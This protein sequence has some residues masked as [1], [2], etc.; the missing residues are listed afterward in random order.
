MLRFL[1]SKHRQVITGVSFFT[2]KRQY[3]FFDPERRQ[4]Q[5]TLERRLPGYEVV[6]GDDGQNLQSHDETR[7]LVRTY[8]DKSL[9]AYYYY[10]R[11][12]RRLQKLA[13][14]SPWLHES[15]LAEVKP[16]H[17]QSRDGLTIHGYLTLP[18]GVEPK[19][20][21]VVVNPHGGPWARDHWGFNPEVQFLANRG[22]AVLQMNFRGSTGYGKAFWQAG[23]KQWGRKMQDDVTR[24]GAVADPAG[25]RRSQARRHLWRL[26]RRLCHPG[27]R[28]LHPG[29]LC[30]RRGLRGPFQPLYPAGLL[31]ALLEPG[32]ARSSTRW[33]ATR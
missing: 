1:R 3:H 23:F 15:E 25:H 17:Y 21:P 19:N 14:V 28:D 24:R 8:S 18:Q 20:L 22:L 2:D 29:P 10:D 11:A 30:L 31:S 4:L 12:E 27:G 5:E 33:S 26:L 6:A 7:V 13:E 16:I 9:G 32:A